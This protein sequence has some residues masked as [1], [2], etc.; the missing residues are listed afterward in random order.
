MTVDPF[1]SEFSTTFGG[2]VVITPWPAPV[3]ITAKS[4]SLTDSNGNVW[5]ISAAKNAVHGQIEVNG[6]ILPFTTVAEI[7]YIA[8][9]VWVQDTA[10]TW[11]S[12]PTFPAKWMPATTSAATP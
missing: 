9:V 10:A 6:Y 11:Y 7:C 2:G 3:T 5:K 12:L 8:P 1:N 4:G